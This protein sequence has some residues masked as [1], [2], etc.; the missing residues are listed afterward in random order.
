MKFALFTSDGKKPVDNNK[1]YEVEWRNSYHQQNKW[2]KVSV[3]DGGFATARLRSD[4]PSTDLKIYR[5]HGKDT[6]FITCARSLRKIP[7]IPGH[8]VLDNSQC[9][10]ANMET[11]NGMVILNKD[12][13]FFSVERAAEKK[14]LMKKRFCYMSKSHS[15]YDEEEKDVQYVGFRKSDHLKETSDGGLSEYIKLGKLYYAPLISSSVFSIGFLAHDDDEDEKY[16]QFLMESKDGCRSWQIKF[17]LP[18][19]T[20]EL[21]QF[22]ESIFDV[23]ITFPTNSRLSYSHTG[24]LLS[25]EVM[26]SS[27]CSWP[28]NLFYDCDR[29]VKKNPTDP[30]GTSDPFMDGGSISHLFHTIFTGTNNQDQVKLES[31]PF[32]PA[33]LSISHDAGIHWDTILQLHSNETYAYLTQRKNKLVLLSYHY[34]MVSTDFGKTWT[35][36]ANGTFTGGEWNFI[37]LDDRTLV[38]VTPYYADV[39]LIE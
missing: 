14:L 31:L 19:N 15:F 4:G 3:L 9:Y 30:V 6:M 34:T 36:Y 23:A 27:P 22:N 17:R 20:I 18:E 33:S 1:H 37:W 29:Y 5:R 7:F 11:M 2:E 38:N 39:M 13:S 35:F 12:W 26:S 28:G 24:K 21:V 8:F 32:D 10:L 25:S 16:S